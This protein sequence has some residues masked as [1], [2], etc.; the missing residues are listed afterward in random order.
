MHL[1]SAGIHGRFI[2]EAEFPNRALD[3]CWKRGKS[4]Q[5]GIDIGNRR[6]RSLYLNAIDMINGSGLRTA[7]S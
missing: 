2:N 6:P 4:N 1:R 5:P 7:R 3:I